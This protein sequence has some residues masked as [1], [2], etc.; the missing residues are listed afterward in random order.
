MAWMSS[1]RSNAELIE[2]MRRSG[3]I[4]SARVAA[5]MKQVDR[6]HYV[7]EATTAYE[8]APQRI[9]YGATIS[10][11][12]MHA[13]ACENLLELLPENTPE[14]QEA[15]RILDVGSGS[16]Y[17][18][19]VLHRI[20]PHSR[21]IGIDHIPNLVA[22]SIDNL[23]KDGVQV[24]DKHTGQSGGV[25]VISG[26]GRKGS[27]EHAP[28]GVIHVGAAAP[29]MP[30]DLVHQLAK[31]GRMFIPVGEGSQAVWQV[32]KSVTG[33]ITKKKLFDVMY[34]PLTDAD[35]QWRG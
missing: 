25:V 32:D 15:P 19:A 33:E 29:H 7:P 22:Q 13:H 14:G 9:G 10:A 28:F 24:L 5:A 27:K 18:A 6:K 20:S 21:I 8:D 3:L 26:D 30:Q 23:R 34:V 12:H 17:L 35:K 1:G 2:N 4:Q 31:P 11:P 16:G